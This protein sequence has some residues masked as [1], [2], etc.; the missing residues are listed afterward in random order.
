[1]KESN[2]DLII[3]GSMLLG[4]VVGTVLRVIVWGI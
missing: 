1:M 3:I 2:L 4:A